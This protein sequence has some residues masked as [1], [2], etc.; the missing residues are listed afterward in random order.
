MQQQHYFFLQKLS[1]WKLQCL[2]K[3]SSLNFKPALVLV[4]KES[5]IRQELYRSE[6]ASA[7]TSFLLHASF[8]RVLSVATSKK[9]VRAR[10]KQKKSD[11]NGLRFMALQ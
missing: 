1:V 10:L 2:I 6:R 11:D 7:R 3:W 5:A 4:K 8:S 9:G